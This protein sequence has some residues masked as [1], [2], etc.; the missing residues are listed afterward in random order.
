MKA[1]VK[2][3]PVDRLAGYLEDIGS[4]CQD[5]KVQQKLWRLAKSL[6]EGEWR[7]LLL[8]PKP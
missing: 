1:T 4:E 5:E 3:H 8:P 6:Y 7:Q 2:L